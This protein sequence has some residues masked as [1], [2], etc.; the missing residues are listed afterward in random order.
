MELV[1]GDDHAVFVDAMTSFLTAAGHHVLATATTRAGLVDALNLHRPA[2][3][4]LES[5]LGDAP[6]NAT[7]DDLRAAS[8]AT[9]FVVLTSDRDPAT[10]Y[11]MLG[12]GANGFVH[13][14]RSVAVLLDVLERVYAGEIVVE[15]SFRS[16]AVSVVGEAEARRLASY[17]TQR[18]LET[19]RLLVEGLD[20]VAMARRLS[21]STTTVRTHVQSVLTKLGVHSRLEA[22]AW[23]SRF[24]LPELVN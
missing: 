23:A 7:L 20:T 2:V 5:L 4:L 15:G 16:A 17:L 10:L 19:L 6:V 3:C 12:S 9:R 8:P 21:V 22:V 24:G 11:R 13:K 1:L 18:E 14:T